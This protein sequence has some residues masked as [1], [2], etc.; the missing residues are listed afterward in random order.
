ML[1]AGQ[2]RNRQRRP[3]MLRLSIAKQKGVAMLSQFPL[4]SCMSHR[5][6]R[7]PQEIERIDEGNYQ[8]NNSG[9][10]AQERL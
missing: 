4:L 10:E 5:K 8:V 2:H 1:V 3:E 6:L 9:Q 7:P